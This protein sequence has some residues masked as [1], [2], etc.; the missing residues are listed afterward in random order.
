MR[1]RHFNDKVGTS[2]NDTAWDSPFEAYYIVI[3]NT[4][5]TNVLF[6]SFDGGSNYFTIGAADRSPIIRGYVNLP[7]HFE[8]RIKVKASGANTT[9]EILALMD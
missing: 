5:A 7:I 4:H 3:Q 1:I 9:F 2:E 6:V 8:K